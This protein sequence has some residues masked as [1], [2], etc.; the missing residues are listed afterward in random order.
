MKP[1]MQVA[2]TNTSPPELLPDDS[3][4]PPPAKIASDIIAKKN[5]RSIVIKQEIS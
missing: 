2:N 4:Y 1:I 5:I 3:K